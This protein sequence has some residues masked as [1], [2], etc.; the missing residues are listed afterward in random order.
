MFKDLFEKE[1]ELI[2]QLNLK[3]SL[4][5]AVWVLTLLI[6]NNHYKT[7]SLCGKFEPDPISVALSHA[8]RFCLFPLWNTIRPKIEK[9]GDPCGTISCRL[10]IR[11]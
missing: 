6:L 11:S 2:L 8:V 9:A 3:E 1:T 7:R 4:S 10:H 5:F